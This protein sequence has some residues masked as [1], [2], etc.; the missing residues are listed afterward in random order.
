MDDDDPVDILCQRLE[1][2]LRISVPIDARAQLIG[3]ATAVKFWAWADAHDRNPGERRTRTQRFFAF[4]LMA[5]ELSTGKRAG[6]TWNH[7]AETFDGEFLEF[8]GI[9][10]TILPAELQ[11]TGCL[12]LGKVLLRA[13]KRRTADNAPQKRRGRRPK[14]AA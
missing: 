2:E 13:L 11:P 12:G 3:A 7:Y 8:A 14:R 5:Y 9:C 10:A 1:V 4:V 6:V